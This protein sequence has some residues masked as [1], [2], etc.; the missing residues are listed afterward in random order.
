MILLT[1]R[2]WEIDWCQNE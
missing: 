2:I 1:C